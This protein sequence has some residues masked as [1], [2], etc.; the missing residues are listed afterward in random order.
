MLRKSVIKKLLLFLSL[1]IFFV[2]FAGCSKKEVTGSDEIA[3]LSLEEETLVFYFPVDGTSNSIKPSGDR[4]VLDE[5]EKESQKALNIKLGF[6]WVDVQHYYNKIRELLSS[7]D[8]FDAFSSYASFSRLE[9][10]AIQ[11]GAGLDDW[12]LDITDLF[13]KY[14]PQYFQKFSK[15]DIAG[16]SYNGKLMGIPSY[17]PRSSRMCAVVRE[18]LAKKYNITDI[19]TYDDFE[20]YLKAIRENEPG[21]TP[22]FFTYDYTMFAESYGYVMMEPFLVYRWND[23]EMKLIPWEQAPEFKDVVDRISRWSYNYYIDYAVGLDIKIKNG[24][25]TSFIAPWD[26]ARL[27]A[28]DWGASRGLKVF[29]LYPDKPA[30]KTPV[31]Q[32]IIILNKNAKNPERAIRFIEWV[33]SSQ[34]NYDLF[35]YGMENVNYKLKDERIIVS[36][37]YNY[38]HFGWD[39]SEPFTNFDYLRLMPFDP[40]EYKEICKQNGDTNSRYIPHMGFEPDFSSIQALV[41]K[42][43]INF[44]DMR[45]RAWSRDYKIDN[46]IGEQKPAGVDNILQMAQKQ[47]DDWREVNKK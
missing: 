4:K 34:K 42:R 46:F 32:S 43:Y 41:D 15:D 40:P 9:R 39:G 18:D 30:A 12:I 36:Q 21:V 6:K 23:P 33:Q 3:G 27:L 14:A 16:A 37:D 20:V 28:Q 35:M 19:K 26:T 25:M 29:P 13:P 24:N 44:E 10:I 38:K 5:I 31:T 17:M 1:S 45:N 7:G 11:D 47:L 8:A 22:A 2:T